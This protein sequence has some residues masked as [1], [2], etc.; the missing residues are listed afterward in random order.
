M[1]KRLK[2]LVMIH[3]AVWVIGLVHFISIVPKEPI[4]SGE[5]DP[6]ANAAVVLT[7]GSMRIESAVTLMLQYPSMNLLISGVGKD[8]GWET[9]NAR[10]QFDQIPNA[11]D[12]IILGN[13]ATN[14]KGN[15][16]EVMIWSR[17][18]YIDQAVL[19]TSNYHYPRALLELRHQSPKT[20]FIPYPVIT[21]NVTVQEAWY[22]PN[23][24]L[25]LLSEYHKY[26]LAKFWI[27]METDWFSFV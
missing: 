23:T 5:W 10:Y 16:T 4:D 17:L 9:L 20:E 1:N 22:K 11:K 26:W 15:A 18:N 24:A 13:I 21:D 6:S 2:I 7:G 14:T 8:T 27:W 3:L 19:I 25:L 12:R